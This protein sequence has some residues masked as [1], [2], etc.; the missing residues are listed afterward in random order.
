MSYNPRL[1]LSAPRSDSPLIF[2]ATPN[3]DAEGWTKSWQ[4]VKAK[5]L[6]DSSVVIIDAKATVE[7]AC[8]LLLSKQA[9]CIAIAKDVASPSTSPDILGL[10]DFS[11]VNAFLTLAATRHKWNAEEMRENHRI[12]E[13]INAAKAGRVPVYLV[14]NLSDKNPMEVLPPDAT[15]ISLLSVFSQGS[16]RAL[17]QS[18]SSPTEYLGIVSDRSLL[19]WFA[20]QAQKDSSLYAYLS[21]TLSSLNLPSLYLYTAVI[22]AKA[23]DLVLDVMRLMSDEGVSSVAIIEEENGSL[24]SAVSV[25]DIGKIVAPSQSNQILSTPLSQFVTLIKEPDGSTDGADKY[26]VYSVPPSSTLLYAIQKVMATNAHRLF[27]TDESQV[28]SPN[29]T[30]PTGTNLSGIVSIVDILSLFARLINIPDVDPTRMQRHRRASSSASSKSSLSPAQEFARSRSSSRASYKRKS[31]G[32]SLR[33][34]VSGLEWAERV[35]KS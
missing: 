10:F 17:I 13:I 34:S 26:P 24:L 27:V 9:P 25:T 28:L 1:S 19:S 11:D 5:D 6:I 15:I 33:N 7:D 18:P 3:A 20:L 29:F 31:A 12:E 8:E 22:A 16:H 23:S 35:P 32:D 21:N 4:E 2:A 14:S 30:G